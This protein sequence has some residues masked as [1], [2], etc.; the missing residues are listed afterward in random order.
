MRLYRPQTNVVSRPVAGI[1]KGYS[2]V[3]HHEIMIPLLAAASSVA[4]AVAESY[5]WYNHRVPGGV[6]QLVR[7]CG[8]YPQWSGVQVPAPPPFHHSNRDA[9]SL[10]VGS[11]DDP[12]VSA[13]A[14]WTPRRCARFPAAR[15]RWRCCTSC[16]NCSS[17]VSSTLAGAAHFNHGFAERM[18]TPTKQFCRSL[19]AS[20]DVKF[21]AGRG[22]V[23]ERARDRKAFY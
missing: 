21:D 6:A 12:A 16:S 2:L 18:R 7:A 15:T 22:D 20:L 19:A 13:A 4:S 17:A 9:R 10:D 11:P 14:R 23:A 1:G 8:S 3:G 5:A